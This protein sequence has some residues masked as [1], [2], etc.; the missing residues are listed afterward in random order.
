MCLCALAPRAPALTLEEAISTALA[1]NPGARQFESRTSS[2][3]LGV[4]VAETAFAFSVQPESAIAV[5]DGED[6]TG[7][8]GLRV[9]RKNRYGGEFTVRGG[10]DAL[11]GSGSGE[12]FSVQY[13]QPLFR[14]AGRLV[15]EEP[16]VRAE[17]ARVSE[18]RAQLLYRSQLAVQ[19]AATFENARR[20]ELQM[21]ADEQALKR[22]ESLY[23]LTLAK[24]RLGR[25]T[26]IDTLRV[27]LQ[28]GEA[29]TR[30]ASTREQYEAKRMRLA[31]LMGQG[32]LGDAELVEP[33]LLLVD[34]TTPA[35]AVATA[36][37]NRLDYADTQQAYRDAARASRIAKQNTK[38]GLKLVTGYERLNGSEFI[39]SDIAGNEN[40][41]FV[42][43]VADTDSN[44]NRQDL[45]YRQSVLRQG[46]AM[47]DIRARNLAITREVEEAL[48]AH[49]RAHQQLDIL[50]GNY[51]HAGAR[52]KLARRL[53]SLGRADGFS[54][55]D[56]E[57]AYFTA[58]SQLL[59]GR[60]E[61]SVSGYR[62]LHATGTLIE[63]PAS[64]K[65]G[66]F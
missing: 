2:A 11:L 41:W 35:E 12:R 53:F 32:G 36:L 25:T 33:P 44:R 10:T 51:E 64:L 28:Q 18:Q 48:A 43:L 23:K 56:A 20:L 17:L 38:P 8:Y 54:V 66:A 9:S 49:R 26:R 16:L 1:Q 45:E 52:L 5:S 14:R 60:S 46:E 59:S 58:Q 19:V 31:E 27:Q 55:T 3:D 62:L 50:E 40:A 39:D 57:Q 6:A 30:L 4:D 61:A 24:E 47:E 21:A 42:R 15:N 29:R 34:H 13:A 7:F 37:N 65:P 63:A 22:A